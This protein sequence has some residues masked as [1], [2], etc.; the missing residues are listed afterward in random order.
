MRTLRVE[1]LFADW[2][3][4]LVL[5][6]DCPAYDGFDILRTIKAHHANIP[7]V[8]IGDPGEL[9]LTKVGLVRLEGADALLLKPLCEASQ[10]PQIIDDAFGRLKRWRRVFDHLAELRLN[11]ALESQGRQQDVT[12]RMGA[13]SKREREVMHLLVEGKHTK[14]IA[15]ELDLSPKTIEHHRTRI[16]KKMK[17][18]SVVEL[19]RVVLTS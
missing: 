4:V 17:V 9:H 15:T 16:L 18:D 11:V 19:V 14:A 13:L 2:Y 8:L 1:E 10:L 6:L 3:R 12:S 5:D 7:V